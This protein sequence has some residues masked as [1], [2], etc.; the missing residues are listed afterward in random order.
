MLSCAELSTQVDVLEANIE[1]LQ[2]TVSDNVQNI[3][4]LEKQVAE[5]D[6]LLHTS[7]VAVNHGQ[8]YDDVQSR[9]KAR[10]VLAY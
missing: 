1:Q 6:C 5:Q 10:K 4:Q 3:T 9:Q 7:A 2:E 8:C